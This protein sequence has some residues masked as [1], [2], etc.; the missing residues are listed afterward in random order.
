MHKSLELGAT[1]TSARVLANQGS[2]A[3]AGSMLSE[4]EASFTER[5]DTADPEILGDTGRIAV[6][7]Q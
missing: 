4:I 1:M 3:W 5:F 2:C 6:Q 7:G